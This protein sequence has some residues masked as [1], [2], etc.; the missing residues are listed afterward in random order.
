MTRLS[1]A[2]PLETRTAPC[3][4]SLELGDGRSQ[5]SGLTRGQGAP[6]ETRR[7]GSREGSVG[8]AEGPGRGSP[9]LR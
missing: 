3:V 8:E 4:E 7:P 2:G 1:K 5:L 6:T 9:H